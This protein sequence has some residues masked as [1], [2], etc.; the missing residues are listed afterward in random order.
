MNNEHWR[1]AILKVIENLENQCKTQKELDN[2][3]ETFLSVIF[4]EMEKEIEYID[5]DIHLRKR[6]KYYKPYWDS[7]LCE[8]WKHYANCKKN[9]THGKLTKENFKVARNKFDKLLV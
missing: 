6:F 9:Y 3:Y 5:T 2:W 8:C 7:E 1:N 4:N